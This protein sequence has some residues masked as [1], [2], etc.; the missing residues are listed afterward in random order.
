M[1]DIAPRPASPGELFSAFA[2]M[3][4][5]G[6]GGVLAVTQREL[7]ERRR[8][9][10]HAEFI[11]LLSM[12]QVLPGPNVVNISLIVG[13]R[14]FGWRGAAAALGGMMLIPLGLVLVLAA[15]YVEH[16]QLPA[17]AG[18]LRGMGAIA[19]G[20]IIGTAFRVAGALRGTPL[21]GAL[22]LAVGTIAFV[23]V[24]LLRLPLPWIL[25]GLGAIATG[26][27]WFRIRARERAWPPQ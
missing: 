8:W 16:A 11:E 9:L 14:Y 6:F 1:P 13:D 17:V 21:G 5:Q 12:A 23:G 26:L 18:A 27:A 10:T 25:L 24:A 19:A 22:A 15:L 4:L 2:R 20:L 7:T 3:S